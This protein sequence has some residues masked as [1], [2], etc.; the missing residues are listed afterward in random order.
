MRTR[1]AIAALLLVFVG[2]LASARAAG[3]PPASQDPAH[4]PAAPAKVSPYARDNKRH[5]DPATGRHDRTAKK[6]PGHGQV[7]PGRHGTH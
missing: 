3:E 2:S 7:A 1:F 5:I 6:A 4:K